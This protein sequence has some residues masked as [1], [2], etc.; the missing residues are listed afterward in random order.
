MIVF[1]VTVIMCNPCHGLIFLYCFFVRFSQMVIETAKSLDKS[2]VIDA[3]RNTYY[4]L[5]LW[6][7]NVSCWLLLS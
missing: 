5:A 7:K 1:C 4:F 6:V 3:V 2:I